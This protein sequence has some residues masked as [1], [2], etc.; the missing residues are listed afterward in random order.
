MGSFGSLQVPQAREVAGPRESL[1]AVTERHDAGGL[2]LGRGTDQLVDRRRRLLRVEPGR[3]EE[4]LVVHEDDRRVVPGQRP[5]LALVLVEVEGRRRQDVGELGVGVRAVAQGSDA[6]LVDELHRVGTGVLVVEAGPALALAGGAEVADHLFGRLGHR[7]D[8][9]PRVRR[10]EAGDG[11][12]HPLAHGVGGLHRRVPPEVHLTGDLAARRRWRPLP[13]STGCAR[14]AGGEHSGPATAVAPT[15]PKA[16]RTW[17][18][19]R[20]EGVV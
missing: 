9:R 1:E 11:G 10:L 8:R 7:V 3:G 16:L 20:V 17:R 6:V 5:G 13:A 14:R 15:S 2:E 4:R 12:G 19:P 18:R